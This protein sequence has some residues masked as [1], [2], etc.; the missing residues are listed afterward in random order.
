MTKYTNTMIAATALMAPIVAAAIVPR[1][2]CGANPVISGPSDVV[3][4]CKSGCAGDA[5][6]IMVKDESLVLRGGTPVIVLK[7]LGRSDG[8]TW[9]DSGSLTDTECPSG[10]E[11][12]NDGVASAM[13]LVLNC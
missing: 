2:S 3:D 9:T 11:P 6:A 8:A 5:V 4:G 10:C 13:I 12:C 1:P 7:L